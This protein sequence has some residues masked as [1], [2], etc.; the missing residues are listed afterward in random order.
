MLTVSMTDSLF[1]EKTLP[2]GH[3]RLRLKTYNRYKKKTRNFYSRD[4]KFNATKTK[5]LPLLI[6]LDETDFFFR[7]ENGLRSS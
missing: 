7:C 2:Y 1:H 6:L 4:C 5:W 3:R